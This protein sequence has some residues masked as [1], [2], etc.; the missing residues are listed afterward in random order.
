MAGKIIVFQHNPWEAPGKYLVSAAKDYKITLDIIRVWEEKIPPLKGYMALIVL[1]GGPNVDQEHIY[2]FL[3]EEKKVIRK[4]IDLDMPYLG[5]CLGHQLLADALGAKV[6]INYRPSIGFI[7]GFLTHDGRNH[8]AFKK[9]PQ[10]LPFFKW[11]GQAVQEPLPGH[12]NILATSSECQVEAISV[13]ERP[14]ILGLQF[15]NHAASPDDVKT[16]LA[17]DANWL[18]SL[19]GLEINPA[20]MI[21]EAEKKQATMK[22]QFTKLFDNFF[23]LIH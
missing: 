17:M 8:P 15:D 4:A 7:E 23:A 20:A 5:F 16:W 10:H 19:N 12:I 11:H 9:L 22:K 18:A 3:T 21:E 2:P 1:G 14:H 13:H 6:G